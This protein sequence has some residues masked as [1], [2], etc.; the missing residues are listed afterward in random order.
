MTHPAGLGWAGLGWAGLQSASSAFR[1][2]YQQFTLLHP[3]TVLELVR[4][5]INP[6]RCSQLV[7]VTQSGSYAIMHQKVAYLGKKKPEIH[8]QIGTVD[9]YLK[10][11]IRYRKGWRGRF[12][13]ISG[14]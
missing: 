7:S 3:D 4:D 6:R 13:S 10:S 14:Y 12:S 5:Y 11:D 9:R 2:Q 1:L 8:S